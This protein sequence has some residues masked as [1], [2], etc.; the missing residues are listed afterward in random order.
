MP[1]D[2]LPADRKKPGRP[3]SFTNELVRAVLISCGNNL[4]RADL[5]SAMV[6]AKNG[7]I[8]NRT[9]ERAIDAASGVTILGSKVGKFKIYTSTE[10]PVDEDSD[11]EKP[12][13]EDSDLD[14]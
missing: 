9:A 13:D 12:M 2:W 7:E 10:K 1:P 4:N 6:N 8:G 14:E 5:T 11:V 3:K